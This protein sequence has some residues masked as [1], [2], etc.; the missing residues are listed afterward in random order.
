MATT[1]KRR[2]TRPASRPPAED[3]PREGGFSKLLKQAGA[4][5]ALVSG[6]V[7]LLFLFL[8][9]LQPGHSSDTTSSGTRLA[10][11][12]S[13]P[14]L[15]PAATRAQFLDRSDR[16]KLG[17]TEAQLAQRGAY[18]AFD[19][20][21]EGFRGKTLTLQREL[22]DLRTGD[23]VG[24]LRPFTFKPVENDDG[25]TWEDFVPLRAGKGRYVLV[26]KL[27]D[28]GGASALDCIQTRPF[29]GLANT[30]FAHVKPPEL[31]PRP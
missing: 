29:G 19:V 5:V 14:A 13:P 6:V 30:G 22:V 1:R 27:L 25:R 11:L 23:Q 3:A 10:D 20:K 28:E 24:E 18:V 17:F 7:G 4:V 31:C 12:S 9:Q 15:D 21:L 26:F 8:P 2:R 16:S